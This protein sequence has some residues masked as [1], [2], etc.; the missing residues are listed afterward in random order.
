MASIKIDDASVMLNNGTVIP[1]PHGWTKMTNDGPGLLFTYPDGTELWVTDWSGDVAGFYVEE[2]KDG[3]LWAI[4]R[5]AI[6]RHGDAYRVASDGSDW[7]RHGDELVVW[8]PGRDA[9]AA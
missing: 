2:L 7:T 3:E 5:A 9:I 8:T 4:G 1:V 6:A